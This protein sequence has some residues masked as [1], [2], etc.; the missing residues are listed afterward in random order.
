[1]A[2]LPLLLVNVALFLL[3]EFLRPKPNLENARPATLDEFNIPTATEGRHVPVVY[4]TNEI[5]G[6]NVIDYGDLRTVAITEKVKTGLFS[7]KKID[8][9]FK[10]YIG[11]QFALCRGPLTGPHDGLVK[12]RVDD[13]TIFDAETLSSPIDSTDA[14]GDGPIT[15]DSPTLFGED[16]G[17]ISGTFRVFPG[18]ETQAVS[19]YLQGLHPE[20]PSILPAYRGT[21]YGVLEQG[22]IGNSPS[23]RAWKFVLRRIPNGLALTGGNELVNGRDANPM[24]VLYDLMTDDDYGMGIPPGEIDTTNFTTVANELATEGNGV[25][26]LVQSP[27]EA[28]EWINE[29]ERQVDGILI[30]DPITSLWKFNLVR[31]SNIPSPLSS[32]PLFDE[33]NSRTIEFSRPGWNET[34]NEVR[35]EYSDPTKEYKTSFALAIDMGNKRIQNETITATQRYPGIKDA[36]LANAIA[37]RDL[38]TLAYPLAKATLTTNRELYLLEPGDPVRVSW[39]AYGISEL[40]MRVTAI[41]Y[42]DLLK[43]EMRIDLVQ[44]IFAAPSAVFSDPIP[45]GWTQPVEEPVAVSAVDQ[46]L[47]EAPF[48]INVQDEEAPDIRP[49]LAFMVRHNTAEYEFYSG[50]TTGGFVADSGMSSQG[51]I[52]GSVPVGQLAAA[53]DGGEQ[54]RAHGDYNLTVEPLTGSS[55]NLQDLIPLSTLAGFPDSD[56]AQL[57][58]LAYITSSTV[59]SPDIGRDGGEFIIYRVA[60]ASG[61]TSVFLDDVYRG[62]IDTGLFAWPAGSRVWFLGVNGF[63]LSSDGDWTTAFKGQAKALP[64]TRSGGTLALASA[65]RSNLADIDD[66]YYKPLCPVQLL[67]SGTPYRNQFSMSGGDDTIVYTRR[68]W[69]QTGPVLSATGIAED[70]AAFVPGTSNDDQTSYIMEVHDWSGSPLGSVVGSPTLLYTVQTDADVS[71]NN[72]ILLDDD[73]VVEANGGIVP[74]GLELRIYA[75]NTIPEDSVTR[76]SHDYLRHAARFTGSKYANSTFL[77]VVPYK[78]IVSPEFTIPVTSPEVPIS[79]LYF[80][81]NGKLNGAGTEGKVWLSINGGSPLSLVFDH[82]VSPELQTASLVFPGSPQDWQGARIA[83]WHTH[84]TGP[85]LLMNIR[86][87]AADSPSYAHAMLRANTPT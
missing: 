74:D 28:K 76:T 67:V 26:M 22:Y 82:T 11:I 51:I 50:V 49:R 29:I 71:G 80:Y 78:T 17:G 40:I 9:G 53:I 10:Y 12:I 1:M 77:G 15:L 35:L 38:E 37:W 69:R 48:L 57:L 45:S 16:A 14:V 30:K 83:I 66:R 20:S 65:T 73:D 86:T 18:T 39:S 72:T 84:N 58:T 8:I 42:G 59:D 68:D 33:T 24:N 87:T 81:I 13:D 63:A 6:P 54:S 7:K 21:F 44:D 43:N 85:D 2:L 56:Q 25:S 27:R 47:M 70:G 32:L 46:I 41:N 3:A 79:T 19:T 36:S 64:K 62:A 23:L 60:T 5:T 75:E 4:G 55:D 52:P 31:D 34:V 61:G